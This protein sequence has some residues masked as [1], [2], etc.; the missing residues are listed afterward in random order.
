MQ[1]TLLFKML[2]DLRWLLGVVRSTIASSCLGLKCYVGGFA[3]CTGNLIYPGK[4]QQETA[5]KEID[6]CE[7][8]NRRLAVDSQTYTLSIAGALPQ[9]PY[10][11][12]QITPHLL[13]K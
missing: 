1:L 3:K 13:Q 11:L 12:P 9:K 5:I 4:N 8:T 2:L 6:F 10:D 7:I